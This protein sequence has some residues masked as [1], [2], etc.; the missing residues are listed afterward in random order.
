MTFI[1]LN[2]RLLYRYNYL[3][4][5]AKWLNRTVLKERRGPL[6]SN[7]IFM[8]ARRLI[9]KEM[10]TG[11]PDHRFCKSRNC[12]FILSFISWAPGK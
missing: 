1:F 12:P 11:T 3:P 6:D 7:T 8:V 4:H 9:N 10:S 5:D 2:L